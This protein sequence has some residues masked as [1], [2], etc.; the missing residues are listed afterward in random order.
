M[1]AQDALY[2]TVSK[3]KSGGNVLDIGCGEGSFYKYCA[4]NDFS[5]QH[6]GCDLSEPE[7]IPTDYDFKTAD[8]QKLPIDYKD[9]TFD[10]VILSHVLEHIY[11]PIETISEAIRVLKPGGYLYVEAPSDRSV[12]ISF[13]FLQSWHLIFSFYD[14][15]THVGRPW[16]PQ[17]FYRTAKYFNLECLHCGYD[18]NFVSKLLLL[19]KLISGFVR[20]DPDTIVRSTWLAL[21]WSCYCVCTKPHGLS[22]APKFRYHSFKNKPIGY[23]PGSTPDA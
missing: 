13:P 5:F 2:E 14:D 1:L 6:S 7:V 3:I 19:P 21:G 11:N 15:P 9:D 17:A 16:T 23:R 12:W 22:G 20:R 4:K 10:F 8:L 18:T